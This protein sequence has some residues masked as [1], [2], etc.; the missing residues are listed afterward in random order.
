MH[1]VDHLL[2]GS[3]MEAS[4]G[5]QKKGSCLLVKR[6]QNY[7]MSVR[8]TILRLV[9]QNVVCSLEVFHTIQ[10]TYTWHSIGFL[11]IKEII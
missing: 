2:H 9:L 10:S 4:K 6:P 8:K 1:V 7:Q 5:D 3:I 11:K